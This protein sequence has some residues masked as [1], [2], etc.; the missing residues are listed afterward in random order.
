MGLNFFA[1]L[2]K[3][4]PYERLGSAFGGGASDRVNALVGKV[5]CSGVP[6]F[7]QNLGLNALPKYLLHEGHLQLN[8]EKARHPKTRTKQRGRTILM[9][10]PIN[11]PSVESS[12]IT[13]GKT[14]RSIGIVAIIC[15][16]FL[17]LK[18]STI[19]WFRSCCS[20]LFLFYFQQLIRSHWIRPI[21]FFKV[22][23]LM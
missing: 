22:L 6:H 15:L 3:L 16:V 2:T 1:L 14:P 23:S 10:I 9:G 21:S 13:R 11:N 17:F 18:V 7:A 12:I 19:S 4:Q 20:I 5:Y 8:R